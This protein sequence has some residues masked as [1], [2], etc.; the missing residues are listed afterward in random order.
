MVPALY[1]DTL[2][3]LRAARDKARENLIRETG[4]EIGSKL[5]HV[6]TK[7]RQKAF[8]AEID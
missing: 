3:R 2:N 7:A 4:K 8:E 5:A 1:L 6:M